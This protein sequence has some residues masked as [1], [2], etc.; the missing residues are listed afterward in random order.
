MLKAVFKNCHPYFSNDWNAAFEVPVDLFSA[1]EYSEVEN[2]I[3]SAETAALN[4]K[5]AVIALTYESAPAF[6]TA[7]SVHT[8][9][10]GLRITE[11][12]QPPPL[13]TAAIFDKCSNKEILSRNYPFSIKSWKP[14]I[15][16][17]EY[18]SS[19]K[20]IREFIA[21]GDTYQ[22]NYTF[23]LKSEFKG[24]SESY[25]N[26]LC[27]TQRAPYSCFIDFG[28]F[29]VLSLSPELF[30][31]RKNNKIFTKP[32]KGTLR[33]GRWLEEDQEFI[34]ILKNCPKN[35]AENLM[36]VDLI[37]ND[38]GR[39]AELDSV[40][41]TDLYNVEKYETV[42][43]MTSTIEAK[44]NP[45][46]DLFEI[47]KS[48]FPCGSITGA[49]KIRTMEIINKLEPYQRGFYT[50][51]IG[52]IKPGGDCIFNV[53]IRTIQLD[54]Q[55]NTA[56]FSVGGGITYDSTAKDEF[57]ECF[58]KSLFLN[59]QTSEF[60]LLESILL[61]DGNYFLLKNH[62]KRIS[63]SA[64]YFDFVLDK[65]VLLKKLKIICKQNKKGSFKIRILLSI[66]GQIEITNSTL[67]KEGSEEVKNITFASSHINSSDKFLYHKTTN[68]KVYEDAK[69]EFPDFDDLILFNE[70][71]EVTESTIA[72][73]VIEKNGKKFTPPRQSGLLAGTFRE[74]LLNKGEIKEKIILKEELLSADKIFLIN[75]VRKWIDVPCSS[76]KL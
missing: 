6:D 41:V 20:K 46:T 58:T 55:K 53:P 34:N 72:N 61:E 74:E 22:V 35:R 11:N 14:L 54:S 67:I 30:F 8:T 64:K 10:N 68:R 18:N 48:L 16:K 26:Q 47:L 9:D 19:I 12:G 1:Y 33:R 57:K 73:I 37:R 36:I 56:I 28:K 5:F 29:K 52:F 7:F 62:L 75:S 21:A 40:K 31:E 15:S 24:C 42:L 76:F 4:G 51:T 69:K 2:L 17:N 44:L 27:L 3:S 70:K 25:Y 32:M 23:P 49:P 45:Q 60:K 50:G 13:A 66:N 63:S 43:Q 71:G 38:L 59:T 65:K 39:I